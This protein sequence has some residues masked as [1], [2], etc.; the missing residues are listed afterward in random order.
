MDLGPPSRCT[1][2]VIGAGMSGL[3]CAHALRTEQGLEDVT[4]LEARGRI[5]GRVCTVF[6]G[7]GNSPL[8]LGAQWLHGGEGTGHSVFEFAKRYNYAC[9]CFCC[10][11]LFISLLLLCCFCCSCCYY[12]SS[13]RCYCCCCYSSLCNCC[14]SSFCCC[15][16][17][18]SCC[19]NLCCC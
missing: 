17:C 1:V 16:C 6:P 12:Y 10:L 9:F 14:Y 8:E 15:C 19:I 11:L 2:A 13:L 3:S 4:V 18:C 5:G 7:E